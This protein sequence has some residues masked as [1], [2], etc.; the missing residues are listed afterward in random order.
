MGLFPLIPKTGIRRSVAGLFETGKD[1]SKDSLGQWS[2]IA[3]SRLLT[4]PPIIGGVNSAPK[5][6]ERK[7]SASCRNGHC[8][9]VR[10]TA[11]G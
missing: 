2:A 7:E 5:S 4:L 6:H 10:P 11:R 9:A 3:C 8:G 1:C